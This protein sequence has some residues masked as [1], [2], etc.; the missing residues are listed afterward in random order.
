MD[1]RIR[2]NFLHLDDGQMPAFD[3]GEINKERGRKRRLAN[4]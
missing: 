1:F 4:A 3:A 2:S